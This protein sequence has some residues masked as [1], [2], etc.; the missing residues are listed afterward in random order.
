M[1]T[2]ATLQV[3]RPGGV[4]DQ[5]FDA[6]A[7]GDLAG[8]QACCTADVVVWHNFDRL[9]L[10]LE[11]VSHG[12]RELIA[13]FAERAFVD[14]RREALADGYVQRH[15]MVA[16]TADGVRRAW[17]IVIF[18]TLRDGRIARLDEYLDRGGAYVV[19]DGEPLTTPGLPPAPAILH[20]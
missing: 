11:A 17:P 5:L 10:G 16:R 7:R 4:I 1:S 12:W 20:P 19:A 6:L 8:A 2:A 18:V 3:E 9:P 15:L 13:N 14:V